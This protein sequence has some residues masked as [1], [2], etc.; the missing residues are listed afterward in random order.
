MKKINMFPL[1]IM[2][3]VIGAVIL[4]VGVSQARFRE[5]WTET[6]PFQPEEEEKLVLHQD[7]QWIEHQNTRRLAFSL[8]NTG[9]EASNGKIYV[10]VSQ[11]AEKA[12]TLQI[13]LTAQGQS[14]TA[15]AQ[16]I[17]EGSALHKSFG[18]GWVYRFLDDQGQEKVWSLQAAGQQAFQ[19]TVE[20]SEDLHYHSLLRLVAKKAE[21]L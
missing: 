16:A 12:E 5:N 6:L 20:N 9:T 8:E 10:L 18:N 19:L 13:T 7:S 4:T 1:L 21:S 15:Q 2:L 14:Y 3:C 11:G 17:L